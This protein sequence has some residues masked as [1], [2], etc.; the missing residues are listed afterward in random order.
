MAYAAN[1][2]AQSNVAN[3]RADNEIQNKKNKKHIPI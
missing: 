1:V 2:C 3:K